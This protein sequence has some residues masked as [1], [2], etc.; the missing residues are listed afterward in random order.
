M[1]VRLSDAYYC[2]NKVIWLKVLSLLLNNQLVL[3]SPHAASGNLMSTLSTK[4]KQIKTDNSV[5]RHV[6]NP[7]IIIYDKVH[8]LGHF[9]KIL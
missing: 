4:T 1:W 5:S 3:L 6:H 2:T 9:N 7:I 8:V